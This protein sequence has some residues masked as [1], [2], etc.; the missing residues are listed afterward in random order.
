MTDTIAEAEFAPGV[1]V[2]DDLRRVV[3]GLAAGRHR[4]GQDEMCRAVQDSMDGGGHL[5]ASAGTGTGKSLAYLVPAALS[6]QPVVIATATKALQ[7][8]LLQHDIPRVR[9]GL[10][11]ELEAVTLKGRSNYLCLQKLAE[12]NEDVEGGLF[13]APTANAGRQLQQIMA[14]SEV[15]ET[16]DQADL[17]FQPSNEVWRSVSVDSRE[18]PGRRNCPSSDS[19]FAELAV[20]AAAM[21]DIVIVNQHLYCLHAAM[22]ARGAKLLP[23][24]K[25]VVIDEA[26]ELEE[27]A[28]NVFGASITLRRF[29]NVISGMGDYIDTEHTK[30]LTDTADRVFLLLNEYRDAAVPSPL[31][32]SLDEAVRDAQRALNT[33]IRELSKAQGPLDAS[34]AGGKDPQQRKLRLL[35]IA[36]ALRSDLLVA[37]D[38]ADSF[39]MWVESNRSAATWRVAPVDVS[40]PLRSLIWEKATGVMCSATIPPN[41]AEVWGLEHE[42][43][44]HIDVGSPFDY[45][46]QAMLF[47]PDG[48]PPPKSPDYEA[49]V[50]D[51]MASLMR[52]VGGRT[53][54]LFTSYK[55]MD[56]AAAEMR[57]RLPFPVLTQKDM[58]KPAL[59]KAFAEDPECCLLGTLGLWQGVDIP[60][61]SLSLVIIARL[62]FPRPD[63]PLLQARRKRYGDGAFMKIDVP[64]ATTRLAQGAGRLIRAETDHGIVAVLDSRLAESRYGRRMLNSLPPFVRTRDR[65]RV[66]R[67]FWQIPWDEIAKPKN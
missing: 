51:H 19:C 32:S 14:W 66:E 44:T 64:R 35:S 8:Q 42:P 34:K 15:T 26:H 21:A 17:P 11:I 62:P 1:D 6:E 52:M 27:V 56:A 13:E 18:C 23:E 33:A 46:T 49:A 37:C 67:F 3:G 60:G 40:G 57:Q 54:A 45:E 25:V 48:M 50:H 24:H 31:P 10:G 9:D 39:A 2:V 47:V 43:H 41:F 12:I 38:P 65:S 55:A 4:E 20:D 22:A 36:D 16:G 63:D 61:Q 58:Q 28:S 5:V 7:D 30:A 29:A 53:L 59:L